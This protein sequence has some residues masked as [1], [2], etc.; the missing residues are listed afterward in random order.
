MTKWKGSFCVT[1]LGILDRIWG[2]SP[3]MG[4]KSL[5]GSGGDSVLD[6]D[7]RTNNSKQIKNQQNLK[8]ERLNCL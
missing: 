2:N 4:K 8:A 5:E 3:A 1:K 6:T 7:K